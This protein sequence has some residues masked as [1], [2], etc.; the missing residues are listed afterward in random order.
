MDSQTPANT[1]T[2]QKSSYMTAVLSI[3][4]FIS[5]IFIGALFDLRRWDNVH[6]VNFF[7]SD[8]EVFIKVVNLPGKDFKSFVDEF[9]DNGFEIAAELNRNP[10]IICVIDAKYQTHM[11]LNTKIV[12]ENTDTLTNSQIGSVGNS[13]EDYLDQVLENLSQSIEDVG[14]KGFL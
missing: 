10:K 9:D 2:S 12:C 8:G 11:T 3:V 6:Q 1:N 5:S 14:G 4:V 13:S 7:L